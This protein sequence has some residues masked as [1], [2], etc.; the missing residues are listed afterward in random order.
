MFDIRLTADWVE[1]SALG[2]A[3]LYGEIVLGEHTERFVALIRY[4]SPLDYQRQW[5]AGIQRLVREAVPS[6][7]ITA[8]D[9]PDTSEILRWWL[10]YPLGDVVAVRES[11]LDYKRSRTKFS[12]EMPYIA[13]PPRR[14]R[15]EDGFEIS[16]WQLPV[17]EFASF[18]ER[19]AK[20]GL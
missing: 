7:L 9:D 8:L 2:D 20:S 16:E 1:G 11:A 5:R 10:L 6:C 15:S 18:L 17:F 13:I 19:Q 14:L 12:T 3:G 4:W